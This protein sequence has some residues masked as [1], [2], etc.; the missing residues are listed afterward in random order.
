MQPPAWQRLLMQIDVGFTLQGILFEI[1][2]LDKDTSGTLG[3][4]VCCNHLCILLYCDL[5]VKLIEDY[6]TTRYPFCDY[7][8]VPF[9]S[10]SR[11]PFSSYDTTSNE[12]WSNY[13]SS[14]SN[15]LLN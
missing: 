3:Q 2:K 9:Y 12:K 10:P 5:Q 7:I 1:T 15:Y 11:Q 13:M 6:K 8:S 14:V 4:P